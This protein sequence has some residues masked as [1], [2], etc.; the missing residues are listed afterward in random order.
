[1]PPNIS[2]EES[3]KK[4]SMGFACATTAPAFGA[5]QLNC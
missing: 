4:A 3:Q 5:A 2:L 1:M